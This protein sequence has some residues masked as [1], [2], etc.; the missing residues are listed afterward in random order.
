MA[1]IFTVFFCLFLIVIAAA[2]VSGDCSRRED[3]QDLDK[4]IN[5]IL[6]K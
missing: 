4:K 1:I 3:E 2:R 5:Q 6:D